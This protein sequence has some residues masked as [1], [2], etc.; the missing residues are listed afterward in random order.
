MLPDAIYTPGEVNPAVTPQDI[1]QT[2][3]ASGWTATVRPPESY[4]ENMK[5]FEAGSGGTVAYA[6]VTYQVHGFHLA[7]PTLGHY[8]LDHLIPLELGGAQADPRN[9][10]MEPYEAPE[11]AAASGT[12]SQTKDKVENASREAVCGGRLG[13]ADAQHEMASNWYALGQQLGVVARP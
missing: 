10:W 8:E 5:R 1:A 6:G 9:L 11:G 7:D 3:C 12:G 13:L 4:T 2:I